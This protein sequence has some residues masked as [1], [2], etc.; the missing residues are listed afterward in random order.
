MLS[1]LTFAPNHD[2]VDWINEAAASVRDLCIYKTLRTYPSPNEL[3]QLVNIFSPEVAFLDLET[4]DE[5]LQAV[6]EIRR[7]HPKTAII[8]L[9]PKAAP[10]V[11]SRALESGVSEVLIAPCPLEEFQQAV[12]RAID[13]RK[14]EMVDNV[15]AFVPAKAG[16]GATTTLLNVSARLAREW[17][18][19]VLVIEADL[20]S[21]VLAHLLGV[22]PEQSLV[23]ALE[24]SRWL[25]DSMWRRTVSQALA[26]DL[27]PMPAAKP[28]PQVSRWEYQRV[29]TFA[30]PR[31]DFVFADLPELVDDA[32]IGI[33]SQARAV[34][35]VTTPER[36]SLFLARRRIDEL[37]GR[38]VP[39]RRIHVVLNRNWEDG[40]D[41]RVTETF[42][43]RE[44][45]LFLPNDDSLLRCSTPETL[46]VPSPA[47]L[48]QAFLG[49]AGMLAGGPPPPK[50]ALP[51]PKPTWR[52]LLR[53][54]VLSHQ[55]ASRQS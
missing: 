8:G 4:L 43:G 52:N 40:A 35:V 34:Y 50:P 17:Q 1:A 36:A 5:A 44:V 14:A 55:T 21:G 53:T 27:L 26:L 9:L 24:N 54:K 18:K 47:P 46:L 31:Y 11:K 45:A 25:N 2:L 15:I 42:L 12:V 51:E 3:A 39:E 29:V 30:R 19:K 23:D 33:V 48:G 32:T 28:N 41:Y 7:G 20:Q 6:E 10:N 37:C 13:S 49:F 16:S 38:D 22:E